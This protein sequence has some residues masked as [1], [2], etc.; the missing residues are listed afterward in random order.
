VNA[1]LYLQFLLHGFCELAAAFGVT[2]WIEENWDASPPSPLVRL[3][4]HRQRFWLALAFGAAALILGQ[5]LRVPLTMLYGAPDLKFL[6]VPVSYVLSVV[7]GALFGLAGSSCAAPAT[8]EKGF[9]WGRAAGIGAALVVL[10]YLLIRPF[11]DKPWLRT[12]VDLVIVV[13]VLVVAHLCFGEPSAPG[14]AADPARSSVRRSLTLPLIFG[15]LPS[16]LLMAAIGIATTTPLG[17]EESEGLFWVASIVSVVCCF[18]SSIALFTRKTGGAIA[19][20]IL[21]MLL[22]G[23][24][25]FFFGCC[26]S[27][28]PGTFR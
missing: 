5:L 13:V 24:I 16:V 23:F 21:L 11:W 15:F 4:R 1:A 25:A 12:A 6:W 27:I 22:N 10:T 3:I 19:G 18:G 14:V 20:G 8:A 2:Y 28:T 7:Y 17:R 9:P 26:A